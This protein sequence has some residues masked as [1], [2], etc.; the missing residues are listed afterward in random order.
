MTSVSLAT[1]PG[2]MPASSARWRVFVR[3]PLWPR[4]KLRLPTS[5]NDGWE[6]RQVLDPVVEY[7]VWPIARWP[8]SAARVRSSN[9]LDTRPISLTTVM[10]EPSDTAMP[11]DSW[12]RCCR[13]KSPR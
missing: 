11:A 1:A 5:R 9:A 8:D 3:L 6:L 10:V 13:A 7:R 4:A 12:P 2:S